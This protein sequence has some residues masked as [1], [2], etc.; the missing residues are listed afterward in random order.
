M[1]TR[2]IT[3]E[4]GEEELLVDSLYKVI[5]KQAL[6][7]RRRARGLAERI[8]YA[9]LTARRPLTISKLTPLVALSTED[10]DEQAVATNINRFHA[11]LY[12]SGQDQQVMTYHKSFSDFLLSQSRCPDHANQASSYFF[13]RTSECLQV[14]D[15]FLHFNMGS[16][17]SSYF[18]DVDDTDLASRVKAN[19]SQELKYACRFWAMH[20]S[21]MRHSNK[22]NT[23]HLEQLLL[24]FFCHKVLFWMETMHLVRGDCRPAIHL[25]RDWAHNLHVIQLNVLMAAVDRLWASF[26][27]SPSS[28]STPHLYI[29]SLATQLA[30]SKMHSIPLSEWQ[31]HFPGLPDVQCMG[32]NHQ[33][34]LLVISH[35]AHVHVHSVSFSPDGTRIVSGSRDHTVRVWDTATGEQVAKMDGHSNSVHS[36]SFSPDGTRIVSGSR[37][38]TVR[39]W[40]TTTGEQVAKMD[41]HNGCVWSVSFS[42]DGTCIVSGSHDHTVQVWDTATGEQVAKMDGHSNSVHSVSFSPDGTRIVSGSDDNTVRVWDMATGEQVAKIDGH[43]SIVWSVSFSPDGTRIVSGSYDTTVRVWDTAI[44]EQVAKMDGHND[45]VH[46]VSFSPDGTRIVSG[47]HDHTVRVWDTTTGEQVAKMDGHNGRVW[48]VSFSPDGT[49]IVSGSDDDTVQVWDT[50]TGEQVAKM[51]GHN[52]IVWSTVQ[53]W[54]TVTGEQVGKMDGHDSIVNSVS[55]LPDGTRIVSG[56]H[57]N[58]VRVFD[59]T[60]FWAMDEDGWILPITLAQS[61]PYIFWYPHTL[62]CTLIHPLCKVLISKFGHTR[63]DFTKA[64]L[65]SNWHSVYQPPS[66]SS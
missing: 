57:D 2:P 47:S 46:S 22:A 16:F 55:F 6:P 24:R 33:H 44:G 53:V 51:N 42:P 48:S 3:V 7:Q 20:L 61:H 15:N 1:D 11:V 12:V 26:M 62:K 10:L 38:H 66:A 21:S 37:D 4:V 5:L 30:M 58:T 34:P 52:G 9:V 29:S 13:D 41:G 39:V 60:S 28:K 54:D 59:S 18:L 19:I 31:S 43:D 64:A 45:S 36:V 17:A 8:L 35:P 56:S 23:Q 49:C 50:A 25:A 14:M 40:D 32:I 27:S 65:G 63:I